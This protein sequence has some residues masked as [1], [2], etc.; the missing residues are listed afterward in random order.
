MDGDMLVGDLVFKL[1]MKKVV[2]DT[3]E[4]ATY[5]RENLT[6]L[7]NYMSTVN[8]DIENFNQYLKVNEDGLKSGG[9]RTD[10][11]MIKYFWGA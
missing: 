2:I 8:S 11:L 5:L 6:N 3:R 4:T 1:T 10:Y 7:E 9:E